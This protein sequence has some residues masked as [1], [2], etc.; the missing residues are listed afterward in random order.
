LLL[1]TLWT[2]VMV[3]GIIAAGNY[4]WGPLL[5]AFAPFWI[6][7]VLRYAIRYVWHGSTRPVWQRRYF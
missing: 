1:S 2:V 6:V 7:Y 4:M 5:I 3:A